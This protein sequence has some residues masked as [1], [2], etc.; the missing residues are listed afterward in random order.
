MLMTLDDSHLGGSRLNSEMSEGWGRRRLNLNPEISAMAE[1]TTTL[2]Q[3]SANTKAV[4]VCV[5]LGSGGNQKMQDCKVRRKKA[6]G[7]VKVWT[8]WFV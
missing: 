1:Q 4:K 3:L 7:S 6:P 8:I 5:C 2:L